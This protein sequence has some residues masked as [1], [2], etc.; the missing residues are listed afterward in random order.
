MDLLILVPLFIISIGNLSFVFS[1]WFEL[2][3]INSIIFQ[4]KKR[5]QQQVYSE[6][7]I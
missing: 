7:T 3:Q 5:G 2:D 1:T 4:Q 6:S